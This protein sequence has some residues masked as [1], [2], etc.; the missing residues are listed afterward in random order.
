[1]GRSSST[2]LN[3]DCG[4]TTKPVA[5][6]TLDLNRNPLSDTVI[7]ALC[8][9][10]GARWLGA[11]LDSIAAQTH[12]DWQLWISDDGSSDD[13]RAV[14]ATF[15]ALHPEHNVKLVDGPRRG[16]AQ[17]FMSLICHPDLP[18]SQFTH[19]TLCDQDD[20]WLP[21]K[22][23]QGLAMLRSQPDADLPLIY[24][25]QSR[26]IDLAGRVIGHSRR[27][28]RGVSIQNA[29]VQNMVSGHSLILNPAALALAREAGQPAEIGPQD[30]WLSLLVLACGGR[31]VVDTTEVL[32]YRQHGAN[33]MGA[34]QGGG[35]GAAT[36]GAIAARYL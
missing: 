16:G 24:G 21:H 10:N 7:I 5:R 14:V 29:F 13:T 31:A 28:R 19:L 8:S 12:K 15:Q 6:V 2:D 30:W 25:A 18:L 23:A 3:L 35:R 11:Q 26:H 36:A 27:P 9:F 32:L 20:I 17:N 33:A 34:P 4:Q 22:L 1:M